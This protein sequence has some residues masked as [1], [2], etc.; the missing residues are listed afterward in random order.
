MDSR[1]K[2]IRTDFVRHT[3]AH[4]PYCFKTSDNNA[5]SDYPPKRILHRALSPDKAHFTMQHQ[6]VIYAVVGAFLQ[7]HLFMENTVIF[8]N[9]FTLLLFKAKR[10]FS[11]IL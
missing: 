1:R 5:V 8:K 4:I 6:C 2:M 7:Q 11:N 9:N 3:R 10:R